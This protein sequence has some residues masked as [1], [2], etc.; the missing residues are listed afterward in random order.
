MYN[1]YEWIALLSVFH[2]FSSLPVTLISPLP[3]FFSLFFYR[4]PS[5]PFHLWLG[6]KRAPPPSQNGQ[7]TPRRKK[8]KKN[9]K[10]ALARI[11]TIALIAGCGTLGAY[12][13]MVCGFNNGF[14]DAI[15]AGT[16]VPQEQAGLPGCIA[17]LKTTYTGIAAVDSQLGVLAGFFCALLDGDQGWGLRVSGYYLM[18]QCMVGWSLLSI[19][20]LRFGNKGR[21]AGW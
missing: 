8:R 20:G 5:L 10:M 17:P 7:H 4:F 16:Q 12:G 6:S 1:G 15:N 2:G 9:I 18:V 3:F 11:G 21:L 19:E 13:A 14:F